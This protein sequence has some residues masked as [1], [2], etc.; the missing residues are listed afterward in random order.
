M[1]TDKI[2][3]T[4]VRHFAGVRMHATIFVLVIGGLWLLW[5][6]SGTDI[7]YTWLLIPSLIWGA[8][9]SVH[10]LIVYREFNKL[11]KRR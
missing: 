11:K 7:L 3:K 4:E 2:I 10:C 1:R 6:L 5:L 8:I 9:F